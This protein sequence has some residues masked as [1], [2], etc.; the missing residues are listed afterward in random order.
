VLAAIELDDDAPLAPQTVDRP[1][2]HLLV[3][4]RKLDPAAK[5][6]AAEA[7]LEAALHL[8]VAGRVLCEGRSE[9]GAARVAAAQRALDVRGAQVV[10]ELG[11]G[12][13]SQ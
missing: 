9:V 7:S 6:E 4:L 12:E 10:L 3:A 2:A 11:F 13:R 5:E 1:G 8:A